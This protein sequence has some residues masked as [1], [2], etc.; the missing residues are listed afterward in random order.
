MNTPTTALV[1]T[2]LSYD[3][4]DGTPV[5]R[6]LDLTTGPGR[7]G[8]IGANGTGKSTLLRLAAGELTPTSGSVRVAG[9]L[10][11][12]PQ[13]ASPPGAPRVDEVLGVAER[14]RALHAIEA[15][16][17]TEANFQALGDDWDIEERAAAVLGQLGLGHVGLDHGVDRLSGGEA[18]LLRLAALLLRRP[19]VLLLDE[20]TNNLDRSAR[21]RLYEAVRTWRGTLVVVS[22]DRELLGG[23]DQIAELRDGAV[24]WYGGGYDAWEEAVA[25]EQDNAEAAVRTAEADVRRQRRELEESRTRQ[26]RARRYGERAHAERRASRLV[27]NQRKRDAQVTAGKQQATHERR[28]E[29]A[30]ERLD[31]AAEQVR[32]DDEI[33]V[34]LPGTV[35]PRGRGVLTLREVETRHGGPLNLTAHGPERIAL[36]GAN[37]SG[38]TTLLRTLTGELPVVSGELA[39]HVPLRALPQ[40]LDVLDDERSL[41]EN[42]ARLAPEAGDER[43]RAQLARFLFRGR[44]AS[45]PAGTLSGGERLRATLAALLLAEPAPQLLLLDEPTNNLDLSGVRR[46]ASALASYQGALLVVSHDLPFLRDIGITRW[47]RLDG[48]L[49]A[50]D[51][52]EL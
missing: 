25:A 23:V 13:D 24:R 49:R 27:L 5:L 31:E 30:R 18:V 42:V 34:A 8:L 36:T 6:E 51:P 39:V 11:Y 21:H 26:A 3:L 32:D 44:R 35:V 7:T 1:C 48:E 29:E 28:L 22:H 2:R 19:D 46:L 37:G 17:A 43:I 47:L 14:R 9:E 45:Q 15:G 41:L 50:V 38:K 12:L 33:T 10:G 4:P 20:P 40:R 16:A 52:D